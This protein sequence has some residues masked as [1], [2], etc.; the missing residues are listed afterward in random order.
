MLKLIR[1]M[2]GRDLYTVQ[3]FGVPADKIPVGSFSDAMNYL[4]YLGVT[5]DELFIADEFLKH[6]P[7]HNSVEFGV[8][9]LGVV[10]TLVT[11][12]S[13]LLAALGINQ[14]DAYLTQGDRPC[15]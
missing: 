14:N 11:D 1:L 6:R 9:H 2:P 5:Q 4:A 13:V 10:S 8:C 15:A 7:D 3:G 12:A